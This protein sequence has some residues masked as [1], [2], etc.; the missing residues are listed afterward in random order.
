[1]QNYLSIHHN[2]TST[3]FTY[4]ATE[5]E[6]R[7]YVAELVNTGIAR[8]KST[9]TVVRVVEGDIVLF[10]R[11]CDQSTQPRLQ[12]QSVVANLLDSVVSFFTSWSSR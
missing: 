1:M 6:A 11:Q 9:I 12:R 5:Q 7:T 10:Y 2:G 8:A 3:T 4:A